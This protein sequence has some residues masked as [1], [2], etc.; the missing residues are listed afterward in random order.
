[1]GNKSKKETRRNFLSILGIGS[2]SLVI[3]ANP[4]LSWFRKESS[5]NFTDT[6]DSIFKPRNLKS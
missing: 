1:M 6:A 4:L 5:S 3:G 2:A